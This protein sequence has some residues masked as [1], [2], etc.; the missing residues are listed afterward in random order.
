M[1]VYVLDNHHFATLAT[2][3]VNNTHDDAIKSKGIKT[4]AH[5]LREAN[6]QSFTG[7]YGDDSYER[8]I[9][10]LT[11]ESMPAAKDIFFTA[12]S[13]M[14]Q[15]VEWCGYFESEAKK[16]TDE[17]LRLALC[18]SAAGGTQTFNATPTSPE[19]TIGHIIHNTGPFGGEGIIVGVRQ[20]EGG[21][22]LGTGKLSG[23]KWEVIKLDGMEDRFVL[24]EWFAERCELSEEN[25]LPLMPVEAVEGLKAEILQQQAEEYEA[26]VQAIK[27]TQKQT[28]EFQA[29]CKT[30][31]PESTKAIII[32]NHV[33]DE[34]DTMSDYHGSTTS[35]TIILAWSKH[36]RDI[37]SEMRKAAANHPVTAYLKD[38]PDEAEHREK[39]SMGGGYYLKDGYRHSTGWEVRKVELYNGEKN[40]PLAE[41]AECLKPNQK[42]TKTKAA[43]K[44]TAVEERTQA[45]VTADGY[46]NI[47]Y[48]DEKNGVEL[49]FQEK[50]EGEILEALRDGPFRYHRKGKFWYA[51]QSDKAER[52]TAVILGLISKMLT[53]SQTVHCSP[54]AEKE[55]KPSTP[56]TMGHILFG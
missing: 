26:R 45:P 9:I 44:T 35:K 38:A 20:E 41:L 5:T 50:P 37:F 43:T 7:R 16:L 52:N 19:T 54:K 40:I 56:L 28:E 31:M 36:T 14:I 39:W 33:E 23:I 2:F 34:S 24:T 12:R 8:D 11:V 6:I 42:S 10:N 48:N 15:S 13:L 47:K 30:I 27:E 25:L 4:I 17:I 1:S 29:Y 18:P 49:H 46:I 51:K 55:S 21:Y 3:L 53:P 22:L 32:A